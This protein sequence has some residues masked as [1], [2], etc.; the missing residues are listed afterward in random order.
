MPDAGQASTDVVGSQS[1]PQD[2]TAL[3][4][5]AAI[6]ASGASAST[7]EPPTAVNSQAAAG[8]WLNDKRINATWCINENRNAWVGITG[9]GWKKLASNSD[10]AIVALSMLG[11]HARQMNSPVNYREEA[12]GMIHEM[13]VW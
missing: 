6:A 3:D 12:D 7:L 9:V 11:T 2:L 5:S 10:S 1:K 13:Y 8:A 4:V